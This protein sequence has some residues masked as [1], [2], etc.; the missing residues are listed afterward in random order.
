MPL[1][2]DPNLKS[3]N[4]V[5][6]YS[7]LLTPNHFLSVSPI[8]HIIHKLIKCSFSSQTWETQFRTFYITA[9]KFLIFSL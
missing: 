2:Q 4:L 1:T 8:L 3:C 5:T 6:T 7:P 9:F